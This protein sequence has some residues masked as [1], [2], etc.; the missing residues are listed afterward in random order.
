MPL[1]N[2]LKYTLNE[3]DFQ[4]Q[5]ARGHITLNYTNVAGLGVVTTGTAKDANKMGKKYQ[6]KMLPCPGG[7]QPNDLC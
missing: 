6:H 3:W 1:L 7:A 4:D 5:L 2:P